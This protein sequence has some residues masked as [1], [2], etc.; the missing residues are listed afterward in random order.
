MAKTTQCRGHVIEGYAHFPHG[1]R[2]FLFG[3][4]VS[5]PYFQNRFMN[6]YASHLIA[7]DVF[8]T[9]DYA[10][11]SSLTKILFITMIINANLS[12]MGAGSREC[13]HLIPPS[14]SMK[15][16]N[17]QATYHHCKKGGSNQYKTQK[18][19]M[20][21]P[22]RGQSVIDSTITIRWIQLVQ[23]SKVYMGFPTLGPGDS[24]S[25]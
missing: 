21:S 5:I 6:Q 11:N 14:C 7:A 13:I 25:H 17:R 4:L 18:A 8:H 20:G 9:G 2:S 3:Y 16:S 23:H 22:P 15:R 10:L 12:N 19:N 24:H 1:K